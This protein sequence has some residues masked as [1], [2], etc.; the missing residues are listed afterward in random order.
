MFT[1]KLMVSVLFAAGTLGA[2]VTPLPSIAAVDIQLNFGPPPPLRVEPVPVP[3]PG[4]V[5]APG[6]WDWRGNRHVWVDGYWIRERPGYYYQPHQWVQRGGSWYLERGRWDYG[7]GPYAGRGRDS[8]RDGIPDR[9]DPHPY[10]Y[11]GPR[12]RDSDRD[13]VPDRR[14]AAPY[15]PYRR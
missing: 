7:R 12:G 8:D 1:K 11:D 5:W 6:Y 4:Y 2:V 10:A 14:D 15:N 9:R 3:R 13:G